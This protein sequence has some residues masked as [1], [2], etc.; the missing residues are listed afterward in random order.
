MWLVH[1]L[2]VCIF[3][4]KYF[5]TAL[6]NSILFLNVNFPQPRKTGNFYS[7]R[8]LE[9]TF[10]NSLMLSFGSYYS[11]LSGNSDGQRLIQHSQITQLASRLLYSRVFIKH[12]FSIIFFIW[13][14]FN[15]IFMCE[16]TCE[17]VSNKNRKQNR[18]DTAVLL[19]VL[20]SQYGLVQCCRH[21]WIAVLN[22]WRENHG[23]Y[24]GWYEWD[25]RLGV[26]RFKCIGRVMH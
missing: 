26:S 24:V 10:R 7:R 4:Y 6:K 3:I 5:L 18:L 13:D 11:L 1:S 20:L 12:F 21:R 15:T 16:H 23:V 19:F 9:V 8:A 17:A 2:Y 22:M 25:V 14:I